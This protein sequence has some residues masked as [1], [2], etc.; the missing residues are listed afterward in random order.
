MDT[1]TFYT[2]IEKHLA[3]H[4]ARLAHSLSGQIFTADSGPLE[5]EFRTSRQARDTFA[6]QVT[7]MYDQ[8][9][10]PSA[11]F[12]PLRSTTSELAIH[13]S[14]TRRLAVWARIPYAQT[15]ETVH[16]RYGQWTERYGFRWLEQGS[17]AANAIQQCINMTK[18]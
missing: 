14:Q 1:K 2:A 6:A 5:F 17:P 3:A 12:F 18:S 4:G 11:M 16:V 8:V 10:P 15:D 13:P 7:L 9:A